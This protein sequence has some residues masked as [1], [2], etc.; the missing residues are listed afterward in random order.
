MMGCDLRFVPPLIVFPLFV[1]RKGI[2][3]GCQAGGAALV[4]LV[5]QSGYFHMARCHSQCFAQLNCILG[6]DLQ[7]RGLKYAY[8]FLSFLL[9][10]GIFK[11][12]FQPIYIYYIIYYI[13]YIYLYII[14]II[15]Y[16]IY[17]YHIY[18]H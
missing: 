6:F 12:F 5:N 10:P 4:Q 1:S 7:V 18:P 8:I 17:Y 3:M 11:P 15:I 13:I 9:E 14:Y 2:G 16:I